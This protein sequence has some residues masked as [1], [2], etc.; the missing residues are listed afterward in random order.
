MGEPTGHVLHDLG[1]LFVGRHE[2]RLT[3]PARNAALPWCDAGLGLTGRSMDLNDF[4]EDTR[5]HAAQF[6]PTHAP[7]GRGAGQNA[8]TAP[9]S[10]RH[11]PARCEHLTEPGELIIDPFAGTGTW[12]T[13]AASMGRRWLGADVVEGGR[14]AVVA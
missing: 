3:H 14:A 11:W 6:C 1:A 10:V 7:R 2:G 5:R 13:I 4:I 9:S 8:S 12:G